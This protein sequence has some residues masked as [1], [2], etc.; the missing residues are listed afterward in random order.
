MAISVV[1]RQRITVLAVV[2]VGAALAACGG[3]MAQTIGFDTGSGCEL[4]DPAT[5]FSADDEVH[6]AA[7]FEPDLK[8]GDDITVTVTHDGQRDADLSA[9]LKL[10]EASD[11]IEGDLGM[12]EPGQYSVAVLSSLGT[13]MPAL[14]GNFE[15]TEAESGIPPVGEVWFGSAYD[16]DTHAIRERTDS[17]AV[18]APMALVTQLGDPIPA[19]Q[20]MLRLSLDGEVFQHDP[21]QARGEGS[22]WGFGPTTT[23]DSPGTLTADFTDLDGRVL[24]TGEVEITE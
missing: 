18:G 13:G 17:L 19:A 20:L 9:E 3:A 11:C 4:T 5:S 10:D 8:T 7:L 2:A 16:P 24:A 21:V 6:F 12:L 14:S 1:T 22:L 15:V 23:P